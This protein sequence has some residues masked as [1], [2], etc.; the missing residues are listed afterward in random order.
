MPGIW[1]TVSAILRQVHRGQRKT[2]TRPF[3]AAGTSR[4]NEKDGGKM[5]K[6]T[7]LFLVLAMVFAAGCA[8]AE[9]ESASGSITGTWYVYTVQYGDLSYDVSLSSVKGVFVFGEDGTMT[10]RSNDEGPEEAATW[11]MAEDGIRVAL[12]GME[13]GAA[14]LGLAFDGDRMILSYEN[15]SYV[16]GREKPAD[17][18]IRSGLAAEYAFDIPPSAGAEDA[19]EMA[20]AAAE[21]VRSRLKSMNYAGAEVVRNGTETIR[22]T[23]PDQYDEAVLDLVSVPGR[24]EFVDPDGEVFMTGEFIQS[25]EAYQSGTDC[26]VQF[27]LTEEGAR[28]FARVTA[29]SIGRTVSIYMDGELLVSATVQGEITGGSV[30]LNNMKSVRDATEMA[31]KMQGHALPVTLKKTSSAVVYDMETARALAKAAEA[32]RADAATVVLKLGDRE[33]TK[34]EVQEQTQTQ[35][36]YMYNL[37]TMYGY[38]YDATDPANIAEA[39]Q[40]VIASLKEDLTL[41]A[42]AH[43]LG[44]DRLT[45]AEQAEVTAAAR[46]RYDSDLSYVK[47]YLI[48]DA[49]SMDEEALTKAAEDKLAEM[50]YTFEDYMENATRDRVREKLREYILRDAE[51]TEEDAQ[52]EYERR[53]A[54]DRETYEGNPGAWTD[55]ALSSKTLYYTPAG[56]RRV[57]QIL[58]KFD[59]ADSAAVSAARQ[60]GDSEAL[61]AAQAKGYANIDEKTDA[62][63]A[64]LDE[65]GAD[66]QALMEQYNDDPGM[67]TYTEGYPVAAGM[68]RFD[69][70]FLEAAMA[71]EK[72]GDHSGKAAG[73]YGY[74]I[75]R[76]DSDEP[77]GPVPYEGVRESIL[78]ELASK[79]EELYNA[80]VQAWIQEA[81][82][83]EHPE[84]FE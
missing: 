3:G 60:Q 23:I 56:V 21:V 40:S 81:G 13:D 15:R 50:G 55:A 39:R 29:E 71:L 53:V 66:W 16:L 73:I 27:T 54:A 57:K 7:I 83:E 49:A 4:D 59:E 5:K 14:T 12:A 25:A 6:L 8:G 74:Y 84:A 52:A 61:A 42:K 1:Y 26:G 34:G 41:T 22:V 76:Y 62:I 17:A 31:A 28:L 38:P 65:E 77:E 67:R 72:I 19:E 32:E 43:E 37:Y 48:P 11:E 46:E 63:L 2:G 36:E 75:I 35:L 58:V 47:E 70:A 45:E 82:I 24:M 33:I 78:T 64:L 30:V 18:G 79:Q 51:V 68:T 9:E 20:E 10:A 80:T 69:P 44:L